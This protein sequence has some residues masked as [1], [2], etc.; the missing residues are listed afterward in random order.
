MTL[1]SNST[2]NAKKSV[3]TTAGQQ[4]VR[5]SRCRG[6][7]TNFTAKF[8]TVDDHR[9]LLASATPATAQGELTFGGERT[10]CCNWP[11][12]ARESCGVNA[13]RCDVGEPA[14]ARD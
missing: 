2:C 12:A 6:S 8:Y 4:R 13:A 3:L 7:D 1:W 9:W 14:Y 10:V 5:G 11:A